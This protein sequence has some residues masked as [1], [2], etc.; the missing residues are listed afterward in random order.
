[1]RIT[2]KTMNEYAQKRGYPNWYKFRE[3]VG[4]QVAQYA[5]KQIE[6]EEE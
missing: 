1:M 5:L 3:H 6:L 4:Y 2:G